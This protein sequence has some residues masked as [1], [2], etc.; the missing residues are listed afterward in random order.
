MNKVFLGW[1]TVRWSPNFGLESKQPLTV[2]YC[3]LFGIKCKCLF[4]TGLLVRLYFRRESE[5]VTHKQA[6]KKITK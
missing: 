2:V 6:I 3:T 1:P 4:S 5:V